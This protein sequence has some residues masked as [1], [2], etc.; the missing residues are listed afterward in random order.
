[1]QQT[2]NNY[3]GGGRTILSRSAV[4]VSWK[5]IDV[6]CQ[7]VNSRAIVG[8]GRLAG[9]LDD[10]RLIGC[11]T[12]DAKAFGPSSIFI[13]NRK[14]PAALNFRADYNIHNHYK[15]HIQRAQS[16]KGTLRGT[17]RYTSTRKIAANFSQ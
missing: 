15:A 17:L 1:V 7:S 8:I 11:A 2:A 16:S 6:R 4:V 3:G 9:R 5:E 13:F 14:L 10:L 12:L